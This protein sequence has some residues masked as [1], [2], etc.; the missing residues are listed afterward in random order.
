[1]DRKIAIITVEIKFHSVI[2][3]SISFFHVFKVSYI[4][5]INLQKKLF[6]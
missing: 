6:K 1:M 3:S 5:H 2:E 4:E